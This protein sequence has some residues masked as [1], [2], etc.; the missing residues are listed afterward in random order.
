MCFLIMLLI[1]TWVI[2]FFLIIYSVLW[3][4][5]LP[6]WSC[7]S[8][9]C[10][11]QQEYLL[12]H[13]L[14]NTCSGG[15]MR[16]SHLLLAPFIPRI[17]DRAGGNLLDKRHSLCG[18]AST[19]LRY[20][21]GSQN[22]IINDS[23]HVKHG[24]REQQQQKRQNLLKGRKGDWYKYSSIIFYYCHAVWHVGSL[25]P[26]QWSNPFPLHWEWRV[27]TSGPPRKSWQHHSKS[28]NRKRI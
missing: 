18:K 21:V 8:Q 24:F 10:S 17:H 14:A 13:I 5:L 20:R 19:V 22:S 26:N 15:W 6:N 7:F 2:P 3:V 16:L 1:D 9:F 27:L 12:F 28:M 4:I 23:N 11:S 25:F